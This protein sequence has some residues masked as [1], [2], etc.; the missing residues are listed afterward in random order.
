MTEKHKLG[1]SNLSKR[2]T[3]LNAENIHTPMQLFKV[4]LASIFI[5]EAVIMLIIS[6]MP[7]LSLQMDVLIDSSLLV[8]F[9]F[10]LL[11]FLIFRPMRSLLFHHVKTEEILKESEKHFRTIAE[12]ASDAIICLK[13]NGNIYLW[14]KKA[15][16]MFG[17]STEEALGKDMHDLIVPE[18]YRERAHEGMKMFF[19]NGKGALV[20]NTV[21]MS[22]MRRDGT[23]FPVEISISS[24]WIQN[25]W[26]AAGIIRDISVRKN[27]EAA[28]QTL[29]E[30]MVGNMGQEFFDKIVN[31]LCEW[32]D[33]DCAIIGEL[34]DESNVEALSMVMD[35]K[36]VQ[37]SYALHGT[38]CASVEEKGFCVFPEGVGKLFSDDRDLV[39]M[40]AEGYAGAPVRDK[41]GNVIGILCVISRRKLSVSERE[42]SVIEIIAAKAAVE[43]ER[44]QV[45]A[46]LLESE[47]RF[48]NIYEESPIGIELYDLEGKLLQTNKACLNIFGVTDV[49]EVKGFGLFED[50]NVT[51]DIKDRL[52]KGEAVRY[53]ALFDFDK[54]KELE[55]YRTAKSGGICLDVLITPL[56]RKGSSI[57]YLVQVQDVTERKRMEEDVRASLAEKELLLKEVHHRVKNNLQIISSLIALQSGYVEVRKPAEILNDSQNRIRSMALIHE[58]LY[59]SE[60]MVRIDFHDYVENLVSHLVFTNPANRD[61][62]DIVINIDKIQLDID[63][64]IPCGL[65]INELV[66]NSIEHAFHEGEEGKIS[67][68]LHRNNDKDC[69]LLVKDN[70]A[71]LPADFDI[72]RLDSLGLQIVNNLAEQIEGS[73]QIEGKGGTAISV[74]FEYG[75]EEGR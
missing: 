54:V 61:E 55:L 70:G 45:M 22:A 60:D 50:P 8:L 40:G 36:T 25:E 43:I 14:N 67:I 38:P 17:Y 51:D 23:E 30:A 21:E 5:V 65:I 42:K 24:M 1:G 62:I 16:E 33:V 49:E 3:S 13:E 63:K 57:G 20:G 34:V 72:E 37:Y 44:K 74:L 71:G 18:R 75:K 7:S 47:E 27:D 41:N 15:E 31:S 53:E 2:I 6:F 46:K 11:Y 56:G 69:C 32:L 66:S 12:A 28:F 4:V 19:Q 9:L 29:L 48:R 39:D 68:E 59:K 52:H 58:M 35:G 73:V 64:A 26:K 10:P